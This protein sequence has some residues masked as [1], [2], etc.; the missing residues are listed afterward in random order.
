MLLSIGKLGIIVSKDVTDRRYYKDDSHL[1]YAIK[2]ELQKKGYDCIKK[3][4]Y[5][6]GHLVDNHMHYIRDRK[7]RWFL[8]D[9]EYAVRSMAMA[10]DSGEEVKLLLS[11]SAHEGMC[12]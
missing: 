8:F 1:M 6:D 4:A 7:Y 10:F 9:S 5:K 2:K 11:A 12:K 3:L